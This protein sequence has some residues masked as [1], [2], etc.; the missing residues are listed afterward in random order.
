ARSIGEAHDGLHRAD[1]RASRSKRGGATVAI[2]RRGRAHHGGSNRSKRRRAAE[3]SQWSSICR[4]AWLDPQAAQ[5]RR[6]DSP[7]TYHQTRRRLPAHAA[8]P[9][10]QEHVAIGP[11]Q[12]VG[13]ATSF[14]T[15]IVAVFSR[16]GYHK[17]LVAIANKQHARIIWA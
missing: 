8:H 17:M 12:A 6:Q 3:L 1:Y 2:H 13:A 10:R 4:L 9:R 11:A 14:A 15:W 7:G 16:I 5:Q